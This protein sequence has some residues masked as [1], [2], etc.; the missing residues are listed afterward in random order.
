M[1][2]LNLRLKNIN[3]LKGEWKIDFTKEPFASSGLFVITGATGA[4]KTT[5][6]DAICLAL[7][8][9]TP[10]LNEPSPADKIMTRYTGECLAEVEFE[11]KTKRYR[12]FWEVKRAKL[13]VDGKIQ[14][15]RV[16][17]ASINNTD[18]NGE[19]E[20]YVRG[21]KILSDKIRDKEKLIA[22]ITGLDFGRF[23]KSMLLAQGS[24]A[25][26]L[27]APAG[28]RAELLEQITGTEIYGSISQQVFERFRQEERQLQL[29]RDQSGTVELLD[30]QALEEQYKTRAKLEETVANTQHTLRD[31]QKKII[32]LEHL[33]NSAVS[34]QQ[35]LRS[36]QQ[37]EQHIIAHQHELDRLQRNE[38]AEKIRTLFLVVKEVNEELEKINSTIKELQQKEMSVEQELSQLLAKKQV[39][40]EK[41]N[42]TQQEI[43]RF[44]TLVS[45]QVIPLDE[46]IKQLQSHYR[47]QLKEQNELKEQLNKQSTICE[48]TL[49]KLAQAQ[50]SYAAAETYLNA[51]QSHQHLPSQIP[52][53]TAKCEQR[54]N[55]KQNIDRR[56]KILESLRQDLKALAATTNDKQ[57][58]VQVKQKQLDNEQRAEE[59]WHSK[60]LAILDCET[61]EDIKNS[62]QRA[63]ILQPILFEARHTFQ[64]FLSAQTKFVEQKKSLETTLVK[65]AKAETVVE[66]LRKNYKQQQKLI[67]EIEHTIKFEQQVYSLQDYRDKL[68]QNEACPLCGATE[69]PAI[70]VY[71][72]VNS[73]A[74]EQRLDSEN[75]ILFELEEA[76]KKA[77]DEYAE[78]SKDC[79]VMEANR[80]NIQLEL[81]ELKIRW[82]QLNPQLALSAPLCVENEAVITESLVAIQDNISRAQERADAIAVLKE[83]GQTRKNKS[84]K[85]KQDLLLTENEHQ[86]LLKQQEQLLLQQGE[87]QLQIEEDHRVLHQ[88]EEA[89]TQQL[90][91]Q[92]Q[93]ALPATQEQDNWLQL[94]RQ[95]SE[96]YQIQLKLFNSYAKEIIQLEND[97]KNAEREAQQTENDLNSLNAKLLDTK[98]QLKQNEDERYRMFGNKSVQQERNRL[99]TLLSECLKHLEEVSAVLEEQQTSCHTYRIQLSEN[100][101]SRQKYLQKQEQSKY[102]WLQALADSVF[103]NE[104]AF[105]SALLSDDE[106][107]HLTK[108][109]NE[110]DQQLAKAKTLQQQAKQTFDELSNSTDTEQTVDQLKQG[111]KDSEVTITSCNKQLGEIEQLLKADMLRRQEQKSIIAKIVEQQ[112]VYDDWDTLKSLIGSSDGKKFRVFAQG[113]TLD[114]LIYLA[115]QQLTQLHGRYQLV[116]KVEEALELEVMDTW[117]ADS[118][119]D[120][121]TLSGGESFLVSLSLALALSDL[122]SH[123]TRIDS[124]FL[125]E[126]FGTLD[127][128]TL[129]I[130]LDALDSLNASGKM[131]GVISHI[132]ALKER[133]PLQIEV[134]KMSGLGISC[135]N[136]RYA[137]SET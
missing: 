3:S 21:D 49:D 132:E 73:L 41:Y 63:L 34:Y 122:V 31:Q 105:L 113:L 102:Q 126:G 5:L 33:D 81:D 134:K 104:E 19:P 135:L 58:Q 118:L 7:Y 86:L 67:A 95:D 25:A 85:L 4:G 53:W 116:R 18:N 75:A 89:L 57:E 123:K 56:E 8:H 40:Q 121:K 94:R 64:N 13:K 11:V 61:E 26:F 15:T 68:Q 43:E 65:A 90:R 93:L 129:E 87:Q 124:L 98:S 10:R 91:E 66:G 32:A 109:K 52:L 108:L 79:K 111:V 101:S 39:N 70:E 78:L 38:P 119:R 37:C 6:L 14:P 30:E 45:D 22:E 106:K 72:N 100:H 133:I 17:L 71:N 117:Q 20:Q 60:W 69:H 127:A 24:F 114:H 128:Q 97:S 35:A 84:N 29:L 44:N 88:L 55:I 103:D 36:C 27:N 9:R 42:N 107:E 1:K 115:N 137:V 48:S 120:T 23:T 82:S 54:N 28:K 51:N 110:L 59:Q 130:A 76:G 83:E 2:I 50:E 125:D 131:I 62:I 12:A 74:S 99:S 80:H 112:Q 77:S 136:K 16:E 96:Q 47:E 46:K 92:Y